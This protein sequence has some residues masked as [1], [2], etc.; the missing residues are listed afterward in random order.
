MYRE[1][2]CVQKQLSTKTKELHILV[3]AAVYIF[4][5]PKH[6]Y[7]AIICQVA[8]MNAAKD[9]QTQPKREDLQVLVNLRITTSKQSSK[10]GTQTTWKAIGFHKRPIPGGERTNEA[11]S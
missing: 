1:Q 7:M 2:L 3:C 5:F 4:P 10:Y 11:P 9:I 8:K 6:A